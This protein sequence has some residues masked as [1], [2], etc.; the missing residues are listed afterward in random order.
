MTGYVPPTSKSFTFHIYC[1]TQT[2]IHIQTYFTTTINRKIKTQ[3]L[4]LKVHYPVDSEHLQ[5]QLAPQ[6]HHL[7]IHPHSY[8]YTQ[9]HNHVTLHQCITHHQNPIDHK[10]FNIHLLR[11]MLTRLL[12]L[13]FQMKNNRVYPN[14][15]MV[16]K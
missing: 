2:H 10:T 13:P 1:C 7:N 5:A 6:T 12:S 4:H 3:S 8:L 14:R 11:Q 15:Q 16:V 9:N